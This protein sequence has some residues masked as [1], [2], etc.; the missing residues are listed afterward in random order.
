MGTPLAALTKIV[1]TGDTPEVFNGYCGAES[2]SVPVSAA[3][4]AILTSELEVQKK[5]TDTD[6]PPILPPPA[7]DVKAAKDGRR[8]MKTSL[9]MAIDAGCWRCPDLFRQRLRRKNRTTITHCR[10]CATKW[11]RAKDRLEL[12]FPGTNQPVR[13]YYMEYR[14]LDLDVREVVAAIRRADDQHAH[15]EPFHE[16]GSARGRLQ[17]GQLEFCER[18]RIPRIH[19]FDGIGGNRSRLRFAAAGF[20]DCDGSGVQGSGG[21][22][23]AEEGVFGQPGAADGYR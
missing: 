14:L 8:A 13:P 2:G 5:Q 3:A 15:A 21:N 6:A 1:A 23:F 4:P 19:R 16:R 12:K 18:R 20:V 22:V 9:R 17:T 7:H 10:R 11:A